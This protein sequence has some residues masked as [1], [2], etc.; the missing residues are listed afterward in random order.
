M[1]RVRFSVGLLK[2]KKFP[3]FLG[4]GGPR[5]SRVGFLRGGKSPRELFRPGD[6]KLG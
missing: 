1:A 6:G 5:L 3:L 4:G 2:K